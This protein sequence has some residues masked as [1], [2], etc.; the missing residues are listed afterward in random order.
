MEHYKKSKL[1]NNS[2]ISKV[3]FKNM[4]QKMIPDLL[5]GQYSVNKNISLKI[6]YSNQIC[7]TIALRMLL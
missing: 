2:T 1:L 5:G 6:L 7:L 3:F 4:D